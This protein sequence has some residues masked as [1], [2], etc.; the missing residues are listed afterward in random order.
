MHRRMVVCI[1][2]CQMLQCFF[3]LHYKQKGETLGV[4]L[5]LM[6]EDILILIPW[7]YVKVTHCFRGIS[8]FFLHRG[9]VYHT[10][11]KNWNIV[12]KTETVNVLTPSW[13]LSGCWALL[14]RLPAVLQNQGVKPKRK[15]QHTISTKTPRK[16]QALTPCS[17]VT[18]QSLTA[19]KTL[20]ESVI[21]VCTGLS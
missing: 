4:Q 8:D 19:L 21:P 20:E 1:Y 9:V 18:S 11:R 2:R 12:L 6:G 10:Q 17:H 16:G 13:I 3:V 7:S 5:L 15:L 14:Y